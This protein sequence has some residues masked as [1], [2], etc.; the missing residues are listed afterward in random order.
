MST[1]RDVTRIVRSWLEEGVTALPDRVLDAVL[2]Q[3]PATRQRRAWWPA[4]RLPQ[5]NT[6]IRIA[7]AAAAVVVLALI[8]VNLIPRTGG[9]G[10][11]PRRPPPTPAPA[12]PPAPTLP[13]SGQLAPGTYRSDFIT[14]TLPAGWSF[15]AGR[16]SSAMGT[17]PMGWR[18]PRWRNIA[19]VYSDPCHWQT[20]AASVG[21]TV[22][23]LVAALVAQKRGSTVTPVDVTIDGFHGK[24]IDLMVPL[25]VKIAACDGGQYKSWTDTTGG[26]RY[27]QGPGQHD[28][29]D[30]L[31]VNGRTLA[32]QRSF[33]PAN[34]AAD[35]AELQAIVDSIKIT[36]C[37]RPGDLTPALARLARVHREPPAPR[38]RRTRLPC[39]TPDPVR[40][41]LVAGRL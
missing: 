27:N 13:P 5:M 9:V 1:D 36:P 31:D 19:T 39:R 35:R 24:Q 22:D 6:P 34:T 16:P 32:I 3:V 11:P 12:P 38:A 30:I 18:S 26:D 28:L 2:D 20:T 8:G 23:D 41:L 15:R 29:L 7:M 17:R 33:Y 21:P 4:R 25:N 40:P 37:V 10:G 14:F